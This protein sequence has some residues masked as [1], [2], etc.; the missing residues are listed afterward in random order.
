LSRNLT[1]KRDALA[2]LGV[3]PERIHVDI[4]VTGTN[5]DQPGYRPSRRQMVPAIRRPRAPEGAGMFAE[6][7]PDP[8][9]PVNQP[10]VS[11]TRPE[12]ALG[13]RPA[14]DGR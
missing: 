2:A 8:P 7:G 12:S 13:G 4:G 6:Q 14:A 9:V 1:P 11:A 3:A 10:S 5:R